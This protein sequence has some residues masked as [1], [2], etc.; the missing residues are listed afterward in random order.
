MGNTGNL[1]RRGRRREQETAAI[2]EIRRQ[3][4]ISR[5]FA[6]RLRWGTRMFCISRGAG[7]NIHGRS[8]GH[9]QKKG[10]DR[11]IDRTVESVGKKSDRQ[12]S[13]S[14]SSSSSSSPRLSSTVA[15]RS[16]GSRTIEADFNSCREF[17]VRT[18]RSII[19][20]QM[21]SER[22]PGPLMSTVRILGTP[23][24]DSPLF[25]LLRCF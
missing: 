1:C 11:S 6:A 20:T 21:R 2:G 18:S 16:A 25:V 5:H 3:P 13:V 24:T 12:L 23:R 17:H 10:D 7:M 22:N 4:S 9:G 14:S 15:R 19:V 8:I